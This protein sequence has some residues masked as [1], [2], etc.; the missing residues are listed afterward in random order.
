MT[1]L[2]EL[3]RYRLMRQWLAG[4]AV[5]ATMVAC[6]SAPTPDARSGQPVDSVPATA[7]DGPITLRT[8][9][10]EYAAG[11]AVGLTIASAAEATYSFNPCTR[12]VEVRDGAVW[13]AVDEGGRVCT[14]EAWLI[15]PGA[16][17]TA[18]TELPEPLAAGQYR[19]VIA[20]T[21]EGDAQSSPERFSATS[22]PFTVSR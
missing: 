3:V 18:T 4:L 5:S 6:Q 14:M 9:G 7:P 11:G 15:E 16:S 8:D 12:I 19:M 1:E 20:F 13:N 22:P 10:A 21:R 2:P 17:R